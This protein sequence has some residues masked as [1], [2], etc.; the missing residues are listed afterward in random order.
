MNIDVAVAKRY[1]TDMAEILRYSQ[2]AS[3]DFETF[4]NALSQLDESENVFCKRCKFVKPLR[5]H[6]CSVCNQCVLIMDHHCMWTNNC[7][8]LKNY[9]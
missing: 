9:K 6:H 7:I 3:A 1:S 8:G 2:I 5:T 4:E